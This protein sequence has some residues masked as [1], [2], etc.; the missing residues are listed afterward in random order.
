MAESF[1]MVIALHVA[2]I[3]RREKTT[4][5]LHAI[6]QEYRGNEELL[7]DAINECLVITDE[8]AV[9]RKKITNIIKHWVLL[10]PVHP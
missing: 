3:K 5:K 7:I 6:K 10:E 4:A 8:F 1:A 2:Y 9:V